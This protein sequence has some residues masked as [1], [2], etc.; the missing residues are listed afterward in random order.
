MS[1]KHTS[2]HPS[3]PPHPDDD[4]IAYDRQRFG[5]AVRRF[6]G[7]QRAGEFAALVPCSPAV[8]SRIERGRVVEFSHIQ[9]LCTMMGAAITDFPAGA[10]GKH[11]DP[12]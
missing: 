8:L 9:R 10:A 5:R 12:S 3:H 11:N 2:L 7:D 4:G 1:Q 6:R